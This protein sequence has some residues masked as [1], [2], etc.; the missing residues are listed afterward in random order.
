MR[1]PKAYT[2]TTSFLGSG[3]S[4][5]LRMRTAGI[6]LKLVRAMDSHESFL[7]GIWVA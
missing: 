3:I 7:I 2:K 1:Y 5:I 6:A 4:T